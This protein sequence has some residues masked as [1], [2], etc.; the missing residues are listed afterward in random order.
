MPMTNCAEINVPLLVPSVNHYVK[1]TRAGVHFKTK[2]AI[3]FRDAVY[4]K[5]RGQAVEAEEYDV[6]ITLVLGKKVRLDIDNSAKLALDSLVYAGVIHSDAAVMEL[7]ITKHR[8]EESST[9]I[10]V[11]PFVRRQP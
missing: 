11:R 7:H 3:A 8:A 10:Q 5:S 2:E 9:K 4:F 6:T 1:H